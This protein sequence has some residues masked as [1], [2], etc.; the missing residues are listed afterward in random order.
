MIQTASRPRTEP[1]LSNELLTRCH[2]RAA[3]YDRENRFFHEDF[4]DLRSAGY[5]TMAVPE[6]LGGRGLTLVQVCRE[7]RRL[8]Y[9][10]PATAIAVNMHIYW[11]GLA[12]DLWRSGDR[13]LEWLLR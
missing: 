13:S 9:H 8:A 1:I 10:A 5:L 2:E 11:T 4:E 7:Q 3:I 6:E 12:A